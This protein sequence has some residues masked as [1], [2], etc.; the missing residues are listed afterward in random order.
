MSLC[1]THVEYVN[2]IHFTYLLSG[3]ICTLARNVN[4]R[5]E[6]LIHDSCTYILSEL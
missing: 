5:Y 2:F 6:N 1:I 4:G 3:E